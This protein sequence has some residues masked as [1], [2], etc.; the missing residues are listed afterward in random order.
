ML[1]RA[2]PAIEA[3]EPRFI[4]IS[5]CIAVMLTFCACV[6]SMHFRRLSAMQRMPLGK[7]FLA[8]FFSGIATPG[9]D[10]SV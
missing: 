9:F 3:R 4:A 6:I 5:T 1:R 10:L 2:L 7:M 8:S